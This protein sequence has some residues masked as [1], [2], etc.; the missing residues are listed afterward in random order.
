MATLC[1][2]GDLVQSA[3]V[4][5][6]VQ[7]LQSL[8]RITAI[9]ALTIAGGC[10]GPIDE[11]TE[12]SR[13][14]PLDLIE[15]DHTIALGRGRPG[16]ERTM[17]LAREA[18][19]RAQRAGDRQVEARI[20]ARMALAEL[21][22]GMWSEPWQEYLRDSLSITAENQL[23][24]VARA[25]ALMVDGYLKGLYL[26]RLDEGVEALSHAT[27][28]G[29]ALQNDRLLGRVLFYFGS[30][31]TLAGQPQHALE[32]QMQS[33]FFAKQAGDNV[34]ELVS[35]VS[36]CRGIRAEA[37]PAAWLE[38]MK[39][40]GDGLGY[41]E[42][43][44]AL[45]PEERLAQQRSRVAELYPRLEPG[46]EPLTISEQY[47]LVKSSK[48]ILTRL[49]RQKDFSLDEYRQL[50]ATV[51]Q[52]SEDL[53]D[54]I[55]RKLIRF[56]RAIVMAYEDKPT[57]AF[58]E[59]Q[60]LLEHWLQV[61]DAQSAA[62]C[63]RQLGRHLRYAGHLHLAMEAMT[64]ADECEDRMHADEVEELEVATRQFVRET[65][66]FRRLNKEAQNRQVALNQ[67]RTL[68]LLLLVTLP[69]AVVF[70]VVWQRSRQHRLARSELQ[71]R[72]D[73]QTKT[74]LTATQ[75][76][77][78]AQQEAESADRAKTEFV[79]R[80]NHELRNPLTAIV[81]TCQLLEQE[82]DANSSRDHCTT[83]KSCTEDLLGVIDDVLDF[84]KI[85]SGSLELREQEFSPAELLE[86]VAA[87]LRPHVNDSVKVRVRGKSHSTARVHADAAKIRQITVNVAQNAARHTSR[88][89]IVLAHELTD[90]DTPDRARLTITVRDTGCGIAEELQDHVFEK[91]FSES[92]HPGSGLGLY[93]SKNF[94]ERMHG[95][96]EFVSQQ[97]MG[98]T[99]YL[100]VP[101]EK[102]APDPVLQPMPPS[103]GDTWRVIIVDDEDRNRGVVTK[104]LGTAGH[105]A[106]HA[107]SW[108]EVEA[109]L[110]D[111]VDL[112]FMD[113]R[114]PDVDGFEM[115]RRIRSATGNPVAVCA[116][117]GDAT[118]TTR[119]R[120]ES[121]GFDG[122]LAKPFSLAMLRE[123][124]QSAIERAHTRVS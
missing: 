35:I 95:T 57:E 33:V 76:A 77:E 98:T 118:E 60:P 89:E 90:V 91:F 105:R 34:Q 75:A 85:E 112:V 47:T 93:V 65:K 29:R 66:E 40:L 61:R 78:Q 4:S 122:F 113:L 28:L 63:C 54:P 2:G 109:A 97:G 84:T 22:F 70:A 16:Y 94:A 49:T 110:A 41:R 42:V 46:Q 83:I 99:F 67:T 58:E 37:R 59:M 14:D 21:R 121:A 39:V 81:G 27:V 6:R 1:N 20:L 5:S 55:T 32:C 124:G 18:Q 30:I 44:M 53:Q 3:G 92:E 87:G 19:L 73:E 72:V 100:R 8:L 119:R 69:L 108:N 11:S 88:G 86:S 107:G 17:K 56:N 68:N 114:M 71:R 9:L 116:M 62:F 50:V 104:L 74:L 79:G 26:R 80:L 102:I 43:N 38:R 106:T 103:S 48:S 15:I 24:S 13:T 64:R 123:A 31:L 36:L 101:V 82:L 10:L 120:C 7:P 51:E 45:P 12:H 117:S 111:D 96:L 115:L 23:P 52:C 25:E